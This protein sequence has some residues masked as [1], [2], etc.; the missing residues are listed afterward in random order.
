MKD[1]KY[2][3]SNMSCIHCHSTVNVEKNEDGVLRVGCDNPDCTCQPHFFVCLP[4]GQTYESIR[5]RVI[6]LWNKGDFVSGCTYFFNDEQKEQQ[7]TTPHIY[8]T[9]LAA[10]LDSR[11]IQCRR[12]VHSNWIDYDV[13]DKIPDV[14]NPNLEW[15]IKPDSVVRYAY[16]YLDGKSRVVT[17]YIDPEYFKK[18][19]HNVKMTFESGELVDI[20]L[21]AKDRDNDSIYE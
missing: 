16:I 9:E 3:V 4:A 10:W 21:L 18:C 19:F 2:Y 13:T 15:R 17:S 8:K 12:N 11:M 14:D 5:G 1:Y 7:G 6:D 20:E